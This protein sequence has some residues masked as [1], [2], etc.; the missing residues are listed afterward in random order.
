MFWQFRKIADRQENQQM[1]NLIFL[2]YFTKF[3]TKAL[4]INHLKKGNSEKP[5]DQGNLNPK[6]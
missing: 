3:T 1:T 5:N 6:L 2:K 4:T